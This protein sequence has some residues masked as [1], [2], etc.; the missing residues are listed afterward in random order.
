MSSTPNPK[1][2]VISELIFTCSLWDAGSGTGEDIVAIEL[3]IDQ[4]LSHY[5]G[6]SREADHTK[7]ITQ[8][9]RNVVQNFQVELEKIGKRTFKE[10]GANWYT[11]TT[12]C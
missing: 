11:P 3:S 12:S 6:S 4:T 9:L 1:F 7:A 8:E 10:E 5:R 2:R